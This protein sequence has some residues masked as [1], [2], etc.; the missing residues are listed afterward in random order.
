[1]VGIFVFV[2]LFL[3]PI[4]LKTRSYRCRICSFPAKAASEFVWIFFCFF[5]FE[6]VAVKKDT[7]RAASGGHVFSSVYI[8]GIGSKSWKLS[9]ENRSKIGGC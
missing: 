6:L 2:F 8:T 5:V 7:R 3:A 9:K 4:L 1:M